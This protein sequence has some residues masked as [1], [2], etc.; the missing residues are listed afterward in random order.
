MIRASISVRNQEDM[1]MA[2]ELLVEM[3]DVNIVRLKNKMCT[4]LRNITLNFIYQDMIVGEI[5]IRYGDMP[6]N[7]SSNHFIYELTRCDSITQF[8]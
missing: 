3:E 4:N 8:R 1:R 2:Y 7:Y 5:Q 6:I